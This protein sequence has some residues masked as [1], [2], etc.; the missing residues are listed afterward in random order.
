MR[1]TIDLPDQFP[2]IVCLCGSTRFSRAVQDAQLKETL[3]GRIV[4]TIGCDLRSDEQIFEEMFGPEILRRVRV[5]N[6]IDRLKRQLDDLHLRKIDLADEV[7][8]LNAGGYIGESTHRELQ[9][10]VDL[11]KRV[12][13]LEKGYVYTLEPGPDV[14]ENDPIRTI[15]S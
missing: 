11:G 5:Q 9:Y 2:T 7:Y 14:D 1:R 6:T 13:F 4:L 12:R 10:A 8:I 3:E 15:Q